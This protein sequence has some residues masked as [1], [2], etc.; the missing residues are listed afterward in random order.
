MLWPLI[1]ASPLVGSYIPVKIEKKVVFPAPFGPK[2]PKISLSFKHI[3]KLSNDFL[4]LFFGSFDFKLLLY[5]LVKPLHTKGYL[6]NSLSP[7]STKSSTMANSFWISLSFKG[8]IFS[9]S[10]LISFLFS[11]SSSIKLS[12]ILLSVLISSSFFIFIF[13]LFLSSFKSTI[14]ISFL[15]QLLISSSMQKHG[16]FLIPYC[17]GKISYRIVRNSK[18]K[19]FHFHFHL[20]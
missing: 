12:F 16:V 11:F 8:L 18:R 19:D 15:L 1:K 7:L 10:V 4:F 17:L 14:S 6:L 13:F 20:G 5:I 9:D 2:S 3:V